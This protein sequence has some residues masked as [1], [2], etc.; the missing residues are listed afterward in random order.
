MQ[1]KV[2]VGGIRLSKASFF[3]WSDT[4]GEKQYLSLP[5]QQLYVHLYVN[6]DQNYFK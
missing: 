3:E 2:S 1:A 5:L 4:T 6:R